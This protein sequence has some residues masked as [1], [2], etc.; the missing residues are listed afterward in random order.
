MEIKDLLNCPEDYLGQEIEVSGLFD[1]PRKKHS[2]FLFFN[3]AVDH[4]H[5][6]QAIV[7][8]NEVGKDKFK[9]LTKQ[10]LNHNDLIT[11][12]GKLQLRSSL[13]T[14]FYKYELLVQDFKKK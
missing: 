14:E 4:D 1:R 11:A 6:I 8:K 5:G 12:K 7:K 3:I 10:G 9:Q 2:D 13:R